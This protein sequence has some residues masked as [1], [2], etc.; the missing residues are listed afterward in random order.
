MEGL[1]VDEF[2]ALI[3][4]SLQEAY[5][6]GLEEAAKIADTAC[7]EPALNE[8]LC[9]ASVVASEIR[10][11]IKSPKKDTIVRGFK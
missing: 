11:L 2:R 8:C 3:A 1:N 9:G 4:K 7:P 10:K 6:R 5:E